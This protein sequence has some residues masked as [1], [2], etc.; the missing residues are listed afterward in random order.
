MRRMLMQNKGPKTNHKNTDSTSLGFEHH[1]LIRIDCHSAQSVGKQRTHNEDAIFSCLITSQDQDLTFSNGLFIIADGM[2][3]HRDG[4]LASA[5][6]IQAASAVMLPNLTQNISADEASDLLNQAVEAAQQA[7][8]ERV[9][10]GGS[11]LTAAMIVKNQLLIAHVGDSRLYLIHPNGKFELLTRDHSLVK[12]LVDLGQIS[13]AEA[14][15]HPHRNVLFR[16]L[17]QTEAFKADMDSLELPKPC[18]LMLCSDGLWGQ[19][20]QNAWLQILKHHNF[21]VDACDDLVQ[22]ANDSGGNDNI[23]VILVKIS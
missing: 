19:V 22:A 7:V 4:E 20:D 3:G 21:E 14:A 17:G 8:L 16:A 6:A 1:P 18:L 5:Y 2:G 23:S 11:T 15:D 10:G 12:R 9:A 13:P